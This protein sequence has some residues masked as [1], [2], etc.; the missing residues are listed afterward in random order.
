[1]SSGMSPFDRAHMTFYSTLTEIMCIVVPISRYGELFVEIRRFYLPHLHLV[2]S[3]GVTP[4]KFFGN[5]KLESRGYRVALFTLSYAQ[6][7]CD[8]RTDTGPYPI[9]IPRDQSSR[10]KNVIEKN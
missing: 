2:P 4:F 9:G 10:R 5:R 3:L 1:M 7:A 6:P 8:R